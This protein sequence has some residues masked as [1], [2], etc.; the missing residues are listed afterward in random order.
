M[1]NAVMNAYFLRVEFR[2]VIPTRYRLFQAADLVCSLELLRAKDADK[3]LSR[4]DLYFFESA[5][6]L[7]KDY[8]KPLEAKRLF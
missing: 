3:A 8:L 4:S 5:R 7:R 1:L 6:K 2:R